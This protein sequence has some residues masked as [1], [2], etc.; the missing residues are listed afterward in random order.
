MNFILP[1]PPSINQTY[2]VSAGG[3]KGLFK[4]SGVRDWEKEAGWELKSQFV[5]QG[6]NRKHF[7]ILGKVKIEVNWFYRNNRDIDAGIKVL[8]DLFEDHGIYKNDMQVVEVKLTKESDPKKPR[9]E[10]EITQL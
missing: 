1:M 9:V 8:L 10:V 4:R 5:K 6:L 3:V 7:P 2:G